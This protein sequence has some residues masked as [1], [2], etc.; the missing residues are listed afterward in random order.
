MIHEIARLEID[1]EKSAE[2]EA[3]V[4]KGVE[5]FRAA[6]GCHGLKLKRCIENPAVYS[7]V[8]KWDSVEHHMEGFRESERYDQW[9][10]LVGPF[11]VA[12]PKVEHVSTVIR[13]F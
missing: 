9:R 1:P 11:F 7:L 12:P 3:A 6:D 10:E 4:T 5:L 13:G 8:V 2:F